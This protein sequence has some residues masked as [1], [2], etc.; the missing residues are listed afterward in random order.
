MRQR[1]IEHDPSI[2]HS[3]ASLAS[4]W[5]VEPSVVY[6][7]IKAGKLT[8]FKV[9]KEFRVTDRALREFEEGVSA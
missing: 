9:G 8:A 4:R 1:T 7:L 2:I 6:R 5:D 3:V